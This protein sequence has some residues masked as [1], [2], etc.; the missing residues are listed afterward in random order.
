MKP[1]YVVVTMSEDGTMSAEGPF[2]DA[3]YAQIRVDQHIKAGLDA[4][5]LPLEVPPNSQV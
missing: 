1:W 2:Y 3:V 4:S 5:V